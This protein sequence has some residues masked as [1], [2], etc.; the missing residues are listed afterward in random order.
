M[1][2][3][4][5]IVKPA[6]DIRE[7]RRYAP[8]TQRLLEAQNHADERRRAE[9]RRAERRTSAGVTIAKPTLLIVDD[10]ESMHDTLRFILR[11]RCNILSAYTA[12]QATAILNETAVQLIF[13]DIRL[14]E[15]RSGLDLLPGIK[16][17]WPAIPV[18]IIS[19]T[20]DSGLEIKAIEMGAFHFMKKD[21][22]FDWMNELLTTS[23]ES[24]EAYNDYEMLAT[25]VD[26]LIEERDQL[27]AEVER[28]TE[29]VPH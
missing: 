1:P 18:T 4:I 3:Y 17:R 24:I 25:T 11:S 27:K 20:D 15:G 19:E 2:H 5:R 14:P 6:R 26:K 10:D 8:A 29:L 23:L 12:D 16:D 22:D 28:L 21:F 7:G 13:L 9:R